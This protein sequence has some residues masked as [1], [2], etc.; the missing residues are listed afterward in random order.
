MPANTRIHV[1]CHLVLAVLGLIGAVMLGDLGA[2]ASTHKPEGEIS[3]AVYVTISP[4]W[5]DPAEV[6]MVGLTP[7][8]FCYALHDPLVRPM[9]DNPM[10]PSLAES[11]TESAD[12]LTYE[13]K[14]REGLRFHNGD[15]FTAEDVKFSF[16]RYKSKILHERVREVEIVDPHRVR[17]HLHRPWPDFMTFYGTMATAAGW[18]VPKK[19][20]EQV[21]DDGFRKHPIGLGPYKFVSHTPGVGLVV[22]AYE[23]YWRKLPHVKRI[24]FKSVVDASTRMAMLK[25]GEVDVAYYLDAAHAEEVKRDPKLRLAFSGG[26]GIPAVNFLEGQW[27]RKSPW[28]DRRVRL[29]ANYAID[30]QAISEAE[31][32]GASIPTGSII[33]REFE[34]ALPIEPYPYDPVKAKQLLA[35]AGYPN[36]FD[37]GD[38][39]PGPPFF[40]RGEM[41]ANYLAAVGIRTR[42]RMMERAAFQAAQ[43]A[44]QLRGLAILGS[45]RYGNAATRIEEA[46]VSTGTFAWGGY[47]DLD[48]LFRQQDVE[49]DRSKREAIL[50]KIQQLMH[51][52]VMFAPLFVFVWPSGIGPRVEESGLWLIKPYPWAAPYEEVR[53]KQP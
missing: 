2:A 43:N 28:H 52:R 25:K 13:F 18:I 32:L 27:D 11:W 39:T 16:S 48:E 29:A 40:A 15:P 26:I 46:V 35:E 14:L 9:P 6:G 17:F 31:T 34:F 19:Y 23:G 12:H 22:E 44:K 1:R 51:E 24:V 38:L 10:V 5:F 37:A 42:L 47:P 36:G 33:P 3:Y 4:A 20:I 7:F 49:T 45:G 8:W 53:L 30:R 21:G 50:H 41:V